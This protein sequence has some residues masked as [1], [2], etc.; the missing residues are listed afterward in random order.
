MTEPLVVLLHLCDSLFPIGS[1]A[2]SDGLEDATTR[3]HVATSA[4]LRQWMDVALTE[5]LRSVE[6][7][8]VSR[9]WRC[10]DLAP[11]DWR[12]V[13]AA[14]D[15]EV[16][17]LSPRRPDAKRAAPWERASENLATT[18]PDSSLGELLSIRARWTLPVAFGTVAAGS[19]ISESSAVEGFVYTRMAATISAAMRLM[20]VGQQ[21]GH[22]V[23]ADALARVPAL[24]AAAISDRSPLTMFA[25]ALD[26]AAMSQQYGH[27]RLFRS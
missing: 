3:Q 19:G 1:F 22:L 2:H 20:P 13:V 16:H 18:R 6:A 26:I 15:D 4:D 24:A 27:S 21:E 7:P 5:T 25:P 23:L 17:A 12:E 8:A 11:S 10:A 9:A 14:L